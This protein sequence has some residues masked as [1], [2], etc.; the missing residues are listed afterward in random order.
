VCVA[1]LTI[2]V[3]GTWQRLDYYSYP[4]RLEVQNSRTLAHYSLSLFGEYLP[5]QGSILTPDPTSSAVFS[6]WKP[7]LDEFIKVA[8]LA[9]QCVVRRTSPISES[10]LVSF[11]AACDQAALV[12][13]P[14][15][16]TS[17]HSI[18]ASRA[19]VKKQCIIESD[20]QSLCV[21]Q[22]PEGNTEVNVHMPTFISVIARLLHI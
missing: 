3:S 6:E 15:F 22:L 10:R 14:V 4:D 18:S 9:A 8:N 12:T 11:T 17:A 2:L 20:S 21:V 5:A 16:A 7:N 13:L 19:G 1:A